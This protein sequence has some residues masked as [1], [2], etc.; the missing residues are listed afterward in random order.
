MHID[1][2]LAMKAFASY[3]EPYDPD[4]PRIALKVAH[5]Y[6][7]AEVA[8]RVAASSGFSQEDV[9]LAWLCG[10][11]HDVGRFEQVRRWNTFRDA[12]SASHAHLGVDALFGPRERLGVPVSGPEAGVPR[13]RDF[14]ADDAEDELLRTAVALHSNYRLPTEL[15]A[16]TRQFCELTR[17]ADKV[18]ILRTAQGGTPETLLGCT[19]DELLDS[20]L[21]DEAITAFDERRCMLRDERSQPADFLV[22]FCCF[23]F[24]LAFAESRAIMR[25]QGYVLELLEHPFGIGEPFRREDTR[26]ELARMARE[27]HD[28]LEGDAS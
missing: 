1:R 26:R 12:Q 16:R 24:E 19:V 23:A 11:L 17:D 4:N 7:V 3:V 13:I 28:Y 5:T 6:L 10:L 25:E 9:D 22:S 27:M 21:S 8:E 14:V 20:A 15:D 2:A 18:D